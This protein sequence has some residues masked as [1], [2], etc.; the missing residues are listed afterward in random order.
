M[1]GFGR[2]FTTAVKIVCTDRGRHQERCIEAMKRDVLLVRRGT[3]VDPDP[4][5]SDPVPFMHIVSEG[6]P[7]TWID[8]MDVYHNPNAFHPLDPDLLP[9]AA[10]HRLR[11]D[12]QIETTTPEWQPL[13]STTSILTFPAE[14]N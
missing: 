7:E 2:G 14:V 11:A 9:G 4:N 1:S 6:Y 5:A 10:H 3:L 12:G 8:G 13:A